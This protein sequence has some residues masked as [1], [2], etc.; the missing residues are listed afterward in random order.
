MTGTDSAASDADWPQP[1]GDKP[2]VPFDMPDLILVGGSPRSG[3]TLMHHI[4]SQDQLTLSLAPEAK[5]IGAYLSAYR[6]SQADYSDY[7]HAFFSDRDQLRGQTQAFFNAIFDDLRQRH[8]VPI[9]LFK[10][11]ALTLTLAEALE[12]FPDCRFVLMLRDPRDMVA[13]LLQV[14]QRLEGSGA[15]YAFRPQNLPGV[16]HYAIKHYEPVYALLQDPQTRARIL[17]VYYE[18]L[19]LQPAL[20]MERLRTFSGLMLAD[21]RPD[22]AWTGAPAITAIQRAWGSELYG[23]PLSAGRIGIYRRLLPPEAIRL[24]ETSCRQYFEIFGYQPE[25][26]GGGSGQ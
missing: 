18:S 14:G 24:I 26:A 2:E 8:G 5:F 10:D 20:E 1:T 12:L 9:L 17:P 11:P 16:I 22:Q 23:Q 21:Y 7:N 13:S 4:L 3:T 25:R 19:V 6:Q 15:D